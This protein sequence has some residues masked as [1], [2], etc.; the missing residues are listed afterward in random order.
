MAT[1]NSIEEL[2]DEVMDKV[3]ELAD[4]SGAPITAEATAQVAVT[5]AAIIVGETRDDIANLEEDTRSLEEKMSWLMKTVESQQEELS[6]LRSSSQQTEITAD[7]AISMAET[8]LSEA[9]MDSSAPNPSLE[10]QVSEVVPENP[11]QTP[12][13]L[14]DTAQT[15]PLP[16]SV[17]GSQEAEVG[18]PILEPV[19]Q[20]LEKR[21][22]M[23]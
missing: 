2:K 11:E 5:A 9:Q 14:T 13:P 15:E 3:E 23:L 1:E 12:P 22:I 17:D 21:V 19:N 20:L 16:E 7:V 10:V 8:A 6:R 4:A 18:P